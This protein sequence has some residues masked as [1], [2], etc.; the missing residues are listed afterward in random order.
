MRVSGRG[1]TTAAVGPVLLRLSGQ[2]VGG[3]RLWGAGPAGEG[4]AE[5]PA[6]IAWAKTGQAVASRSSRVTVVVSCENP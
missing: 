3:V 2:K 4:P 1:L 5:G 6:Q